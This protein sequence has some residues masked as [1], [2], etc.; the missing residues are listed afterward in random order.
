[1]DVDAHE[2][3]PSVH[4]AAAAEAAVILLDTSALLWLERGHRRSRPLTAGQ[5]LYISPAT[6]LELQVLMESGRLRAFRGVTPE[7]IAADDRWLLD[8]APSARWFTAAT[9]VG[10]TRDPFDRLIVAH[11]RLRGWKLAT[12]DAALLDRLGPAESVPL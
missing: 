1:M 3:R 6:L 5:R 8:D 12:S 11:A 7:T 2:E 9:Q 10:W 4:T